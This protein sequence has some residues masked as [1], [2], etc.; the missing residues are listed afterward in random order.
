MLPVS[1]G[2]THTLIWYVYLANEGHSS[3][4][5]PMQPCF[6]CPL[7]VLAIWVLTSVKLWPLAG[8]LNQYYVSTL[9]ADH[10]CSACCTFCPG[11]L[12]VTHIGSYAGPHELAAPWF[13]GSFS[14][15]LQMELI[16]S[17]Q[18]LLPGRLLS[19]ASFQPRAHSAGSP[20]AVDSTV[21]YPLPT[22]S[23]ERAVTNATPNM[24]EWGASPSLRG[25]AG[26]AL[27][28]TTLSSALNLLMTTRL[29]N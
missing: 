10:G 24:V 19:S 6:V 3:I 15:G 18:L 26:A 27:D 11:S 1:E 23:P 28:Q 17:E 22:P 2:K 12:P 5:S 4:K 8:L 9:A 25:S 21:P 16:T 7:P 29:E 20:Q 14:S 13:G